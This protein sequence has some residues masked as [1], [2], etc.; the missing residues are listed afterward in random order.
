MVSSLNDVDF[1]KNLFCL[2]DEDFWTEVEE[3]I[4]LI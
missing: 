3:F 1:W 4:L 2:D